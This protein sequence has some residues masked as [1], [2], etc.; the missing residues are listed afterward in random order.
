M[1]YHNN[2]SVIAKQIHSAIKLNLKITSR[3]TVRKYFRIYSPGMFQG[4]VCQPTR[5]TY[6]NLPSR[7]RELP[8]GGTRNPPP[9]N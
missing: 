6:V 8:P 9:G 7:Q 3:H 1:P 2:S 4:R 5:G